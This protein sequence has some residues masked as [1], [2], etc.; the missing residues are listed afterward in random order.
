MKALLLLIAAFCAGFLV[1]TLF[2]TDITPEWLVHVG[3][4]AIGV[5]TKLQSNTSNDTQNGG[6][7]TQ[8]LKYVHYKQGVFSPTKIVTKKGNRLAIVNDDNESLMDLESD[9]KEFITPRAYGYKEELMVIIAG[10]GTFT[11]KEKNHTDSFL[12]IEVQ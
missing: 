8:S 12:T 9:N 10:K 4:S 11:V 1:H 5:E 3:K 2:F 6:L 7:F